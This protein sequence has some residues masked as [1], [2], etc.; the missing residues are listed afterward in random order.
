[1]TEGCSNT[2][3]HTN[4]IP[5]LLKYPITELQG[6]TPVSLRIPTEIPKGV[7]SASIGTV[8]QKHGYEIDFYQ[9]FENHDWFSGM[10]SG[11][12]KLGDYTFNTRAVTL[13]NGITAHFRAITCGGSCAPVNLWWQQDGAQ[14]ALQMKMPSNTPEQEQESQIVKMANSVVVIK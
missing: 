12:S 2:S 9:R 10:I 3:P 11:S 4:R 5:S 1:M 7:T 14:Y 8:D 13:K 6:K